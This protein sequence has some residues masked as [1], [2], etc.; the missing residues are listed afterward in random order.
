MAKVFFWLKRK[1]VFAS[2]IYLYFHILQEYSNSFVSIYH[3]LTCTFALF[4]NRGILVALLLS[5]FFLRK[6]SQNFPKL[7]CRFF[8][9]L[10]NL[11]S[12]SLS[13]KVKKSNIYI[14][15][16]WS[17]VALIWAANRTWIFIQ[18]EHVMS[19]FGG[20]RH[21]WFKFA[22]FLSITLCGT[23][24]MYICVLKKYLC[25]YCIL[26]YYTSTNWPC[27]WSIVIKHAWLAILLMIQ[28]P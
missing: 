6:S 16:R 21:H 11:I 28:I 7:F 3:N 1:V 25:N 8:S 9:L 2:A 26:I 20:N 5:M 23:L 17:L 27:D 10:C 15:C 19:V 24:N 14:Y 18:F 4:N 22:N 12:L 13:I